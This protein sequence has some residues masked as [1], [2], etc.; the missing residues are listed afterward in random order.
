[1]E[2]LKAQQRAYNLKK[3]IEKL[4]IKHGLNLCNYDGGIGFI[5]HKLKKIVMVWK[6]EYEM[7]EVTHNDR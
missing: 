6:P 2:L 7:P 4:C 1:M 3:K 5:D